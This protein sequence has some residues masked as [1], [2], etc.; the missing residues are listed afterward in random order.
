MQNIDCSAR[1]RHSSY[2]YRARA[3]A[4]LIEIF[5]LTGLL[6]CAVAHA[7]FTSVWTLGYYNVEE[8]YK[9]ASG[10]EFEKKHSAL[11]PILG[12]MA[13]ICMII[14]PGVPSADAVQT[15]T[16]EL[17]KQFPDRVDQVTGAFA[18]CKDC[19][20]SFGI[21]RGTEMKLIK[22]EMVQELTLNMEREN[23]PL[24]VAI[25]DLGIETD[26][27]NFFLVVAARVGVL[28]G[29]NATDRTEILKRFGTELKKHIEQKRQE[30]KVVNVILFL[31]LS[32]DITTENKAKMLRESHLAELLEEVPIKGGQEDNTSS[33]QSADLA[34]F[35][36]RN[37]KTN[38]QSMRH[39]IFVNKGGLP[40]NDQIDQG[41]AAR[42]S[43][44][45]TRV[46]KKAEPFVIFASVDY[47]D[48]WRVIGDTRPVYL[49]II[50]S[51]R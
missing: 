6:W 45:V 8:M 32:D 42:E 31:E 36:Y 22:Q 12:R 3:R 27:N 29:G 37:P 17:N 30:I 20:E 35:T 23:D 15:I 19:S 41:R 46:Q 11:C 44:N 47:F 43:R 9:T 28:P 16:T 48:Q 51:P 40:H 50:T 34:T 18:T 24:K 39:Y 49:E 14:L 21:I 10:S 4:L 13:D 26:R 2:T 33:S 5:A 1:G 7:Q 38:E 25:L